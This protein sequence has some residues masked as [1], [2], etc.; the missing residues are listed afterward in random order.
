[1]RRAAWAIT[2]LAIGYL[3]FRDDLEIWLPSWGKALESGYVWGQVIVL[4]FL[5]MAVF[6]AVIW[7]AYRGLS[8]LLD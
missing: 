6:G 1:M 8:Y 2:G 5:A 4:G 3:E 7:T